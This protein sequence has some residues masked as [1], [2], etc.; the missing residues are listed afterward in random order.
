M[1]VVST[2]T[3]CRWVHA[4]RD[5]RPLTLI[6]QD[7]VLLVQVIA[8]LNRVV[9]DTFRELAGPHQLI[10]VEAVLLGRTTLREINKVTFVE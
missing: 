8:I 3:T 5:A 7:E 1:H 10:T 9:I 4:L 6:G 2:C